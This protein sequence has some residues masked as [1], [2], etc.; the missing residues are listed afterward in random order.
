VV[1]KSN[2]QW[3]GLL[4][5]LLITASALASAPPK[6]MRAKLYQPERH[7]NLEHYWVSEKLDGARAYWDG[8]HLLSRQG[9][10]FHAPPWFTA[11]FPKQPLDGE[12]WIGRNTFQQLISTVRKKRPNYDAWREVR[13]MVFD[14]P[15]S[16]MPFTTRL[17]QLK[18]LIPQT[19]QNMRLVEQFR[20]SDHTQLMARLD[21]VIAAGGEGLMLHNDDS[22]YLA[23][24][25]SDLLKVKRFQDAEAVVTRHLPGKG[26]F[27]GMLGSIEVALPDGQHFRIGSG[28][29][30][31][32]RRKPPPIG[33]T[34][35]Y[36]YFGLSKKGIPRFASFL[37]VREHY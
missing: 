20:V 23:G 28:F 1:I 12:L 24:R 22:L 37:R 16:K 32:E 9:N 4:L 21:A 27:K 36:R 5:S 30:H 11:S 15:S 33:S 10:I 34:I 7:I 19:D 17:V 29:S 13:Y 25:S 35:T 31:Q 14:L 8:E 26:K 3:I 18:E 2:T 6:V